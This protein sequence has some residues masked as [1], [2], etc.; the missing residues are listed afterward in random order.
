M[1][2]VPEGGFDIVIGNPPYVALQKNGGALWRRYAAEGYEALDRRGDLYCLFFE[3]GLGLL[4]RGGALCYIT[5]NK[6]LRAAY[7]GRLRG[8]VARRA[9]PA[10][11]V[12]MAGGRVFEGAAVDTAVTLLLLR[13]NRGR[14]LCATAGRGGTPAPDRAGAATCAFTEPGPWVPL[15]PLEA[16]LRRKV[17]AAGRP[18]GEWGVSINYGI[19]TGCNEA[20]VVTSARREEILARCRDEDERRRTEE[21]IRPVLRGDTIGRN[22]IR[23]D[24][25]FLINFHDGYT[26]AHGR[27]VPAARPEDY[28]AVVGHIDAVA[29]QIEEGTMKTRGGHKGANKGFYLRTDCGATPYNL[30]PCKYVGHFGRPKIVWKQTSKS[31]TFA[32]D[33]EGFM[34]DVSGVF[35]VVDGD[36]TDELVWLLCILNSRVSLHWFRQNAMKFGEHGVRWI[37]AVVKGMPIPRSIDDGLVRFAKAN[38]GRLSDELVVDEIDRRVCDAYGLDGGEREFLRS[39]AG[40]Y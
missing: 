21:I 6:W 19:K 39:F 34:L 16:G 7:G 28:P 37:P 31:Q 27:N 23:W 17:E 4:R 10:M 13:P 9:D 30:R 2:G 20:F 22:E 1:M 40:L 35:L 26:D 24:G 38:L 14:T 32:L 15:S 29:K 25:Q 36:S 5:S 3:R 8:L 11:V 12:D 33:T 18:L